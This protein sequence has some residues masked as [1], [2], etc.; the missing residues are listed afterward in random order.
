MALRIVAVEQDPDEARQEW[1]YSTDPA[2]LGCRGQGH[3][4]PKIKTGKLDP[5]R[6]WLEHS[7]HDGQWQL[8]QLCRDGCGTERCVTTNPG[9]TDIDLPARFR[10]RRTKPGYSPPA[11]VRV[12]RREC[13]SEVMRRRRED[14]GPA[15]APPVKFR[16]G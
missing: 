6:N 16:A 11:G 4:F 7:Q 12:T 15:E 10:Y 14:K 8:V 9:G 13:F 3:A 1:L 5:K 2:I